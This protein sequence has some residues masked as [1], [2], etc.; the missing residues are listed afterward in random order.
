MSWLALIL[1][2]VSWYD[3]VLNVKA[4]AGAFNQEKAL[5]GAFS[6]IVKTDGL[7]AALG[8]N[9]LA[10]SSGAHLHLGPEFLPPPD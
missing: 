8:I 1:K 5:V 9:Q 10:R 3:S 7:F 6:L 4:I 2:A